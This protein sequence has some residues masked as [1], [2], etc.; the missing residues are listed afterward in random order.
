MATKLINS[1]AQIVANFKQLINGCVSLG[2]IY[3]PSRANLQ[4]SELW[5]LHANAEKALQN[6]HA[7]LVDYSRVTN[8]RELVFK[9]VKPLAVRIVSMFELTDALPQTGDDARAIKRKLVGKRASSVLIPDTH[10]AEVGAKRVRRSS[11]SQQSYVMLTEHFETLLMLVA[12]EPSYNPNEEDLKIKSLQAFLLELRAKND[13]VIQTSTRLFLARTARNR[14][15]FDKR[16]GLTD[17]AA[18]IKTFTRSRFG[19]RSTQAKELLK[20]SVR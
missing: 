9:K 13:A 4:I 10:T 18:T 12:S 14:I 1:H 19:Y 5:A 2:P 6:V 17:V 3:N 15:M 16:T 7:A 20:M 8:E 11:V